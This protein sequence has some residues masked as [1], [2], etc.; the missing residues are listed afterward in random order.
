[1]LGGTEHL[2]APCRGSWGGRDDQEEGVS[3]GP[4]RRWQG[5]ATKTR[6]GNNSQQS[7]LPV[8]PCCPTLDPLLHKPLPRVPRTPTPLSVLVLGC[9][10]LLSWLPFLL[11]LCQRSEPLQKSQPGAVGGCGGWHSCHPRGS[12]P[13]GT[14]PRVQGWQSGQWDEGVRRK[15]TERPSPTS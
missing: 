9:D 15:W 5:T 1:M 14:G 4:G 12:E 8:G 3:S 13:Q 7:P 11:R 10:S 6:C 2:L